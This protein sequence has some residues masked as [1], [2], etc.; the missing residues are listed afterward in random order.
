MLESHVNKV[1]I[2]LA[3]RLSFIWGDFELYWLFLDQVF[4]FNT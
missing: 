4:E 1:Q 3:N 2:F